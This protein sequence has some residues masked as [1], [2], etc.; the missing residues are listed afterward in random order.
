MRAATDKDFLRAA[1]VHKIW[2][3]FYNWLS[4]TYGKDL[5]GPWQYLEGTNHETGK[6][7]RV[8]HRSF[9]DGKLSERLVGYDVMCKIERYIKRCCPEIKIVHCDDS[10]YASSIILL[11]PHPKHGIRIMYIPQCTGIQNQFFLY[12]NHYKLFMKELKKM[13]KVYKGVKF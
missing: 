2:H 7:F 11:I 3:K 9:N 5:Y 4:N 8:K 10:V 6:K 13:E 12:D 1:S